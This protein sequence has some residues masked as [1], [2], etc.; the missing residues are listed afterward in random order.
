MMSLLAQCFETLLAEQ[1]H[2][3]GRPLT[4]TVSIDGKAPPGFPRGELL[5]V[6]TNGS[7]NIAVDPLKV[8]AWMR[9]VG[10][11]AAQKGA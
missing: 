11:A 5:S 1:A 7:R 4:M 8:L 3:P 10:A 2:Q 6:G 9:R